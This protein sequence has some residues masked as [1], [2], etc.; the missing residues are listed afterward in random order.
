MRKVALICCL[1]LCTGAFT[2]AVDLETD[3]FRSAA[4]VFAPDGFDPAVAKAQRVQL[5]KRLV[6]ARAESSLFDL[7]P[8]SAQEAALL[9]GKHRI[10]SR[11][12]LVG[13]ARPVEAVVDLTPQA[14][15]V[16]SIGAVRTLFDGTLVWS[17]TFRSPGATAMRARLD[18]IDLPEGANLYVYGKSSEAFGPYTG[19]GEVWTNTVLGEQLT[20][21]LEI[22]APVTAD[23]LFDSCFVVKSIGHMGDRFELASWQSESLDKAFCDGAGPVNEDC[24]Y[25]ASCSSVPGAIG[26]AAQAIGEMLYQSGTSYYICTGGLVADTTG[27]MT[28]YFLT[29]NHCIST[30]TEASSL[31]TYWDF[32]VPCGITNCVYAW[33]GGRNTPGATILSTNSTSDYTLLQLAS[34]PAGRAFLGWSTSAVA[35]SNGIGLYRLSH[36]SGAPQAYSTH[37]VTTT[38]GTC[39]SWPRGNWIYSRDTYGATEGGSSGSPVLNSTGLIVGQ[40]SGGCGTNVY[41]TCDN[42]SNATV[43]GAFAAYYSSVSGWLDPGTCIPSTEIC[44]GIDN[45][46][47]GQ[48]DED[49]V[50]GSTCGERRDPCTTDADCCSNRCFTRKGYCR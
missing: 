35:Y 7:G 49:D 38:A 6:G 11:R 36:P 40:L 47:D 46:C 48:I 32:I 33:D 22:A 26:A 8:L 27:T 39:A 1:L 15:P 23:Q 37:S 16:S 28:P 19:I 25:N 21:Q 5:H 9:A 17:A 14:G 45:D 2:G 18:E 31:E 44:D 10:D 4:T 43:D 29:A 20:L 24:I 50:C 41:E 13:I 42:V 12:L 34:V 30:S 3:V